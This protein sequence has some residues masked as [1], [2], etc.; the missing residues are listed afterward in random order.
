MKKLILFILLIG[1][2]VQSQITI[3]VYADAKLLI[4]GDDRGNDSGTI[5]LLV[6]P[7][8][9]NGKGVFFYPSF[10]FADLKGGEYYRYAIGGGYSFKINNFSIEPSLDY[11]RINRWGGT[12]S[13]FNG[14][15]EVNYKV[16]PKIKLGL[17]GS[18]TQRQD[19]TYKWSED[20]WRYN[21]YIGLSYQLGK[22][23]NHF[24]HFK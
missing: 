18:F 7:K 13:S 17:L 3:G 12:Y 22:V 20:T 16:T 9:R 11:G 1:F 19:L 15:C 5:D 10:E 23:S 6:L 8:L 14:L 4:V 24:R 21:I 2:T